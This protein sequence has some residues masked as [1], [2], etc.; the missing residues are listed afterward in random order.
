MGPGLLAP[1]HYVGLRTPGH[2]TSSG[3]MLLA[4][5][6]DA[7]ELAMHSALESHTERTITD[8][9]ELALE[10]TRVR[11]RGWAASDEEWEQHITAVAVPLRLPHGAVE[12]TLTVTGPTHSLPPRQFDQAARRMQDFVSISSRWV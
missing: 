5:H 12:A 2:A 7:A 4:H 9:S 1:R 6:Q 3:K 8:P 11:D 10:F